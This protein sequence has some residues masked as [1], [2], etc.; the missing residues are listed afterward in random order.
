MTDMDALRTLLGYVRKTLD[1]LE[2]QRLAHAEFIAR[3]APK[4]DQQRSVAML[5]TAFLT[6]YYTCAETCF[7]RIAQCFENHLDGSRWH[8]DLLDRMRMEVPGMRTA[9]IRDE[10]HDALVE[11]M[12]F[13]HFRR[14]YFEMNYDM[15]KIDFLLRKLEFLHRELPADLLR[16]DRFLQNMLDQMLKEE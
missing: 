11:L 14:Y 2:Q 10:V 4:L 15:E 1:L 8:K 3:D 12:R 7:W 13:R 16:F 6:D 5:H 9:V